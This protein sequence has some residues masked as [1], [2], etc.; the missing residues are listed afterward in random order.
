M[1]IQHRGPDDDAGEFEG[2]AE[3]TSIDDLPI[4]LGGLERLGEHVDR[5]GAPTSQDGEAIV[6]L[7]F[8]AVLVHGHDT[9]LDAAE[10]S[11]VAG[12]S[13]CR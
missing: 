11:S 6:D 7:R 9:S 2:D 12:R 4:P 8:L 1:L 5:L 3:A 13:W 10:Q